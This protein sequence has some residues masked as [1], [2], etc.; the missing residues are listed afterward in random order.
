MHPTMYACIKIWTCCMYVITFLLVNLLLSLSKVI[1]ALR[2]YRA[3]FIIYLWGFVFLSQN[4]SYNHLIQS[5]I[6]FTMRLTCLSCNNCPISTLRKTWIMIMWLLHDRNQP[7][8]GLGTRLTPGN[9]AQMSHH[10]MIYDTS[11]LWLG[12]LTDVFW[13]IP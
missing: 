9:P 6:L 13:F 11:C 2:V 7:Y 5:F 3:V 4:T 8:W 1:A 12:T 10:M